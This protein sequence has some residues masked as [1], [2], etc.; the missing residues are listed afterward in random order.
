MKKEKL[1]IGLIN[2]G[3]M[4][5]SLILILVLC[6][7]AFRIAFKKTMVLFP[8]YQTDVRYGDFTIRRVKPN[9]KYI[10]R[11]YDGVFDFVSNN[12]G[13][14]NNKDIDY[15]NNSNELR[16]L[17]L[18]DSHVLGYEVKQSQVFTTIIEKIFKVKNINTV[19][20][21]SGVSG[22]GTAEELVLLE[23]EGYKY[24]PNFVVL[25]FYCNDF[26]NN[27]ISNLYKID[28]NSLVINSYTYIPGTKIQNIIYKYKIFQ[29]LGENSY[30]YAYF[31]N[32]IWHNVK[33][34]RYRKIENK[35][36]D[37]LTEYVN[38]KRREFPKYDIQLMKNLICRINNICKKNNFKLII[39]DIP[40]PTLESS[41][42][43]ELVEYF[44]N[45][46]DTLF[47]APSLKKDFESLP[48]VH[49]EHGHR[50]ISEE[51]HN[52]FAQKISNYIIECINESNY[53]QKQN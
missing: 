39:L 33:K 5:L 18:G 52:L 28:S 46:C 1:K 43:N 23:N 53:S 22:F 35:K 11:S 41:I 44:K 47:Y 20:I 36:E 51:T 27:M 45:N 15:K 21:N 26:R 37:I 2:L 29:I 48:K 24:R 6:E 30:L 10:H 49:V 4:I 19:A 13:F 34:Y 40:R 31:F 8:R 3:I 50:H 17:C 25:G 16:I 32:T 9:M 7:I 14:R 42:P 12:K 38:E